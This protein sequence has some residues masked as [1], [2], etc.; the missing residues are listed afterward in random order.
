[1]PIA[2]Q[3]QGSQKKEPP[4]IKQVKAKPL[5][6]K[7]QK[8]EARRK[9]QEMAAIAEKLGKKSKEAE[10]RGLWHGLPTLS[11]HPPTPPSAV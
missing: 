5:S 7:Q 8:A 1:M 2:Y 9:A 6:K 4:P 10:V 11:G 3:G